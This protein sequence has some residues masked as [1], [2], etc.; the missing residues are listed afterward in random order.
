MTLNDRTTTFNHDQPLHPQVPLR[1]PDEVM[2]LERMGAFFPTRL[3]F[4]RIILRRLVR[5]RAVVHRARW[6]INP[7]GFGHTFGRLVKHGDIQLSVKVGHEN[8]VCV[9]YFSFHTYLG[10]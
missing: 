2:R 5:E 6:E 7:E 3:S 9:P 8:A 10:Q 4:M 1:S